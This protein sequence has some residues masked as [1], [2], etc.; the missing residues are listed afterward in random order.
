MPVSQNNVNLITIIK[1]CLPKISFQYQKITF[2][3]PF[4]ILLFVTIDTLPL[5]KVRAS[6]NLKYIDCSLVL[7]NN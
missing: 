2:F 1:N 4:T 6:L 7:K 3:L 5:H